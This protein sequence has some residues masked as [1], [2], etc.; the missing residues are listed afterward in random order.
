LREPGNEGASKRKK[1]FSPGK[2]Y[3]AVSLPRGG[4]LDL[5]GQR[6]SFQPGQSVGQAVSRKGEQKLHPAQSGTDGRMAHGRCMPLVNI[7][8]F[9][10]DERGTVEKGLKDRKQWGDARQEGWEEKAC[11]GQKKPSLCN[12][13]EVENTK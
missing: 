1:D 13:K 12:W 6:S 7:R 5:K 9:S 8:G 2:T 10:S 4:Q 3:A 11:R